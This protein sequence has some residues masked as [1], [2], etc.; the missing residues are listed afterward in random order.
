[1]ENP[2]SAAGRG[3]PTRGSVAGSRVV[4]P[5]GK[6]A[7]LGL[8]GGD[9]PGGWTGTWLDASFGL[10]SAA[11]ATAPMPAAAGIAVAGFGSN[12]APAASTTN[13]PAAVQQAPTASVCAPLGNTRGSA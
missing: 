6:T 12:S 11:C 3:S 8:A 5:V 10:T 1:M 4:S 2:R 7:P 13:A 9:A